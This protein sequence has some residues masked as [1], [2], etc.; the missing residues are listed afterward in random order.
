MRP[1]IQTADSLTSGAFDIYRYEGRAFEPVLI[2]VEGG[3]T[4]DVGLAGYP[5][6]VTAATNLAELTPRTQA[7]FSQAGGPELMVFTPETDDVYSIVVTAVGEGNYA[8]YMFDAEVTIPDVTS[9]QIDTLAAGE[10]KSYTTR[11]NG[12][13][14][15][16]IFADPVE[17]A[18][19][20]IQVWNENGAVVNQANYGGGGSAEGL[21]V[22]PLESTGYSVQISEENGAAATYNIAVITLN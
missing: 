12:N 4:L 22:L 17:E 2:F 13:R 21:Y 6:E 15:V 14:P 16:L 7:D 10:S 19:L 8:L 1:G 3:G 11:S 5:G 9:P 18:D 20:A